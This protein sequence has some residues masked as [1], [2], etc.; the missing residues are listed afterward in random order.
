MVCS[1]NNCTAIWSTFNRRL[2]Y[3]IV[4]ARAHAMLCRAR[5]CYNNSSLSLSLSLSIRCNLAHTVILSQ[6]LIMM[7]I[8][9]YQ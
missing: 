5:Y 7:I 6:R 1:I 3:A 8:S 4:I 2:Y 9:Q